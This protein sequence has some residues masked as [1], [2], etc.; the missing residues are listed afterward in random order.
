MRTLLSLSEEERFSRKVPGWDQS[1]NEA[2]LL[3]LSLGV[4]M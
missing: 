1:C 3:A 2:L 4:L